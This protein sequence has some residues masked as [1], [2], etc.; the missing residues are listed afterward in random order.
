VGW[1]SF[2]NPDATVRARPGRLRALSVSQSESVVVSNVWRFCVGAQG[3]YP[4]KTA[5]SGPGIHDNDIERWVGWLMLWVGWF[6]PGQPGGARGTRSAR[7]VLGHGREQ[8]AHAA[9]SL[10]LAHVHVQG[11][12]A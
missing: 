10:V 11:A 6:R 9:H 4:P 5:V 7:R 2:S 12:G 8:P 3:A 1:R